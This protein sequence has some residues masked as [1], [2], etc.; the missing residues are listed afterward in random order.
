MDFPTLGLGTMMLHEN[1][2]LN[3]ILRYALEDLG[4]RHLDCAKVYQNQKLIGEALKFVFSRGIVK[5]KD[6]WI[7]S[8]LWNHMHDPENV[9]RACRNT[10]EELQLDYLDL[11]LIHHAVSTKYSGDEN[12]FPQDENGRPFVTHVPICETW[13]A[14]E[15]LVEKK[16]TRHIGVSNFTISMLEKIRYNNEVRIQPFTNQ[17]EFHIYMQQQPLYNYMK[18]RGIILTGFSPLGSLGSRNPGDKEK[19]PVLLDDPV[20]NEIA[21]E[22]N[23]TPATVAIRF[24]Q[25]IAPDASIIIKSSRKERLK[26]NIEIATKG[27]SLTDDQI[28][29]LRGCER[30][31]RYFRLQDELGLDVLGDG[32]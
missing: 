23:E 11:Y 12:L 22:T 14:M 7:T 25:Q 20:L 28:A 30:F 24:L 29:K 21:K 16:L 32:W 3:E 9:E 1:C 6:V 13:K 15:K 5:R 2:D 4:Y 27:F 17:V 18:E 8:K 26:E 19:E 31:F 10:L